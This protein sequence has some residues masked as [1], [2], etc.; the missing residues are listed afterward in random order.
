[1]WWRGVQRK[2][3][4]RKKSSHNGSDRMTIKCTKQTYSYSLFY[5]ELSGSCFYLHYY[6]CC[7]CSEICH[8]FHWRGQN[9]YY[10][11]VAFDLEEWG[12][13]LVRCLQELSVR[14][15]SFEILKANSIAKNDN[16]ILM[17]SEKVQEFL[18]LTRFKLL[19][20]T[21]SSGT[22]TAM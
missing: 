9:Y 2:K 8:H 13:H 14:W 1:M 12:I 4:T 15:G 3:T 7:Y 16:T 18:V 17:T 21:K 20:L 19:F 5:R 6:C 11:E 10:L 22:D